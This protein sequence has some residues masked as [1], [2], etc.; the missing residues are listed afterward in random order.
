[1]IMDVALFSML[2]SALDQYEQSQVEEVIDDRQQEI[3]NHDLPRSYVF[4][5]Y[6]RPDK[7]F[8]K[9]M[10]YI[11]QEECG[12][13]VVCD[14]HLRAGADWANAI[15]DAVRN[16]S[17]M[18]VL[19]T[20]NV[21]GANGV[22]NEIAEMIDAS[23]VNEIMPVLVGDGKKKHIPHRIK[24]NNRIDLRGDDWLEQMNKLI[25]SINACL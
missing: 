11:L 22:A 8:M 10:V 6:A 19:V 9:T 17:C 24:A 13:S 12:I 20:S 23:K 16:A 1:M 5:S 25:A 21:K 2:F 3:E 15:Q 4:I 14:E 18:V 7:D